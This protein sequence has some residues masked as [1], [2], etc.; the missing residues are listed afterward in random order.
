MNVYRQDTH[1]VI[2]L[3]IFHMAWYFFSSLVQLSLWMGGVGGVN[4]WDRPLGIIG[5]SPPPIVARK[6]ASL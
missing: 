5:S 6:V 3:F 2:Y 4:E 1:F